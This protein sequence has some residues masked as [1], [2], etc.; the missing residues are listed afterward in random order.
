[1][2]DVLGLIENVLVHFNML[3]ALDV[4]YNMLIIFNVLVLLDFMYCAHMAALTPASIK[5]TC[6]SNDDE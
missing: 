6:E 5:K 4:I 1:M 3:N 2:L